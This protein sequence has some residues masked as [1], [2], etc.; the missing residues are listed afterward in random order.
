MVIISIIESQ[1]C[2]LILPVIILMIIANGRTSVR[3]WL[4]SSSDT[5]ISNRTL[6]PTWISSYYSGNRRATFYPLLLNMY[7]WFTVYGLNDA[8][9]VPYFSTLGK[10]LKKQ[11]Q[12]SHIHMIYREF[13]SK[14]LNKSN[15]GRVLA[16][17]LMEF[18]TT[19]RGW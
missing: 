1:S 6:S 18:S 8:S 14:S 13:E 7:K 12:G 9:S 11:F 5:L 2:I 15:L 3:I 19:S 16:E 10:Q 4:R 17:H